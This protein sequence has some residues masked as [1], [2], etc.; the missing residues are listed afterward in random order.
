MFDNQIGGALARERLAGNYEPRI[1]G[2]AD[3]APPKVR[4]D[5]IAQ[6]TDRK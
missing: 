2:L 5:D 4:E 6:S 3:G 1:S